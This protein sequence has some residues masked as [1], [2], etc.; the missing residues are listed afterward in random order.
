MR[1]FSFLSRKNLVREEIKNLDPYIAGLKGEANKLELL[2]E[3][4]ARLRGF[5]DIKQGIELSSPLM[6]AISKILDEISQE[7][8]KQQERVKEEKIAA[9]RLLQE[10]HDR[11][12]EEIKTQVRMLE[13]AERALNEFIENPDNYALVKK[14]TDLMREVRKRELI[15]APAGSNLIE[16][17]QLLGIPQT[18]WTEGEYHFEQDLMLISDHLIEHINFL[19]NHPDFRQSI[20]SRRRNAHGAVT[21]LGRTIKLLKLLEAGLINVR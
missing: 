2:E 20:E 15:L 9:L 12:I 6:A 3:K 19:P 5:R 16:L 21:Y 13:E 8:E 11:V 10:E 17:Q 7:T 1:I 14:A 4:L 18:K